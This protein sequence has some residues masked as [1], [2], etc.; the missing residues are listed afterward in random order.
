ME[1][2]N[3]L[4]NEELNNTSE[5]PAN[6]T[7]SN[8]PE[9]LSSETA[10]S[11]DKPEIPNVDFTLLSTQEIVSEL[12]KLIE[13][14]APG[15]IKTDHL[16]DIFEKQY[17]KEFD[18]ALADF[19]ADGT[20]ATDFK[21]KNDA[22]EKFYNL[23]KSLKDKKVAMAKQTEAEREKNL[24]IK[25]Q[26]IEE[27]KELVQKEE[28]LNK[29]FQE[30]KDIQERWRNTGLVPQGQVNNLLETYHHHVENFYNYI[31]INKELRDLDLKKNLDAKIKLCEEA[32]QLI[33]KND[34]NEAFKQLQFLHAQWKEIGPIPKEQQEPIWERFK[35]ATGKI[36]ESYHNFFE[37][38]KQEQENNLKVKEE[39]CEKAAVIAAAEYNGIAEWNNGAKALLD[40]QEEWKHS[41]TVPQKERNRIFKTFRASCDEFFNRKREF[42]K[43]MLV[44][45]EKNLE[46][47][48]KLCEKVEAIQDSTEWKTTTDR[49]ISYQKEWKKIG[50]APRKYS[51]KVWMRFRAACDT[52][53]NN[54]KA[55]F[56]DIDS[57]QEKNMELKKALLE[58]VKQ[59]TLSENTEAN[60]QKLKDFQTRW[61][62]IGYVPIKFK[63][64]LQDEFR[65]A[66]NTYFDKMNLD[67]FDKNLEKYRAKIN[68]LDTDENKE[69]KIINER[70]KLVI[71]IR[72]LET[73]I[74]T[75]ENN[76]GFIAKSNKSEGLI[77]ELKNK[78]EK[79][80]QRLALLQEKLKA[81]DTLI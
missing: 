10:E 50:P 16:P 71:K 2:D 53:F 33:E 19:T 18:Q 78:I 79:T 54:K 7:E 36:N 57:E 58:E 12:Q 66:I 23:C 46:L 62:E 22:K 29:T 61:N 69:F 76:I 44:D 65:N 49:I 25:L 6:E 55:H 73:D 64:S 68:A 45:Q 43:Q 15:Q 27:L 80:K 39:I 13:Q 70:E 56:K 59:F 28:A 52:F 21:Y 38:L 3:T 1:Q 34:I 77:R 48:I 40:L 32:E 42:Y 37:T 81:L 67:E 74:N 17:Q 4:L 51:N 8:V 20:P 9:Q 24:E 63:D 30:F 5:V 14:Y 35:A 72:Q 41:G 31:K 11:P 47:K 75:W 26:L 60:I